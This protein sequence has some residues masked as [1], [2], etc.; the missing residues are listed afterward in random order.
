MPFRPFGPTSQVEILNAYNEGDTSFVARRGTLASGKQRKARY[1][2]EIKSEPLL[3]DLDELNL[4]RGPAEAIRDLIKD[5]INGI[6]VRA[7]KATLAARE[8]AAAAFSRGEAWALKRYGG[9]RIGAMAP[10]QSDKLYNDSGRLRESIYVSP[11]MTDAVYTVNVAANRLNPDQF[12]AGHAGMVSRLVELVPA[13]DPKKLLGMPTVERAIKK[14]SD[15]LIVKLTDNRDATIA[16]G[17]AQLRSAQLR[18]GR[19]LI[20]LGRTVLGGI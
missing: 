8:R 14:A 12:G 18:A 15:E 19:A 16:R 13:L 2:F 5:Q 11:N 4:G 7:S 17:L 20:G 3:M 1:S 9:G 6:A 10:N